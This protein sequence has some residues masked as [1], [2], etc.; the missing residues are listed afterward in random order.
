MSD[1][2]EPSKD[3]T[4]V[5]DQQDSDEKPHDQVNELI[6]QSNAI[7]YQIRYRHRKPSERFYCD[8]HDKYLV[9]KVHVY[10]FVSYYK[11]YFG[12]YSKNKFLDPKS[13]DFSFAACALG[14][15]TEVGERRCAE[16]LEE[17]TR[18]RD[19]LIELANLLPPPLTEPLEFDKETGV[20]S[21]G[22]ITVFTIERSKR[23]Y[24]ALSMM[25]EADVG[26][27]V[28]WEDIATELTGI[29]E[30]ELSK[31]DKE[32]VRQVIYH[33]NRRVGDIKKFLPDDVFKWNKGDIYRTL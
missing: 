6:A 28:R 23:E 2:S 20:L 22:S 14:F 12:P 3:T 10:Q 32:A 17:L 21:S 4:S 19:E 13:T 15:P 8:L 9:W 31:K 30:D 5:S 26:E 18:Q 16:I 11:E 27:I 33:I 29:D 1:N 25:L 24:L 7:I